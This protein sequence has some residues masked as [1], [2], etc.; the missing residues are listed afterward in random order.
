MLPGKK[1]KIISKT[2]DYMFIDYAKNNGAYV[3]SFKK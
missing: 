3:S 1:K 2:S